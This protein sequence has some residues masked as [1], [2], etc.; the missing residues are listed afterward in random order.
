VLQQFVFEPTRYA[1]PVVGTVGSLEAITSEVLDPWGYNLFSG[2]L[3]GPLVKNKLSFFVSG[4]ALF[5][6]DSAPFAIDTPQLSDEQLASL[7]VSPQ[8]LQVENGDTG[9]LRYLPIPGGLPDTISFDDFDELLSVPEGFALTGR[10]PIDAGQVVTANDLTT[11]DAKNEPRNRYDIN[12]NFTYTPSSTISIRA[13]GAFTQDKFEDYNATSSLYN[14]LSLDGGSTTDRYRNND[15]QTLRLFTT[16]THRISDNTFYQLQ[17]DFIDYKTWAYPSGFSKN[18]DDALAVG[19]IDDPRNSTLAAYRTLADTDGDGTTDSYVRRYRDGQLF[20]PS[21]VVSLWTPLGSPP[22]GSATFTKSNNKQLRFSGSATTQVGVHQLEFGGEFEQQTN[23]FYSVAG[24]G[25]SRFL[26]DDPTAANCGAEN[27]DASDVFDSSGNLIGPTAYNNLPFR[28]FRDRANWYGYDFRGL[29]EVDDQNVDNYLDTSNE[30]NHNVE[31]WK[32]VYYAGYIQD[33]I[34]FRDLVINLGLRVDVFDSNTLVLKDPG[35]P[36][37]IIRVS[38]TALWQEL[39]PAADI[40]SN[41]GDDYAVYF[42]DNGQIVGFR[43]IDGD[44]FDA[45]GQDSNLSSIDN[46]GT[47]RQKPGSQQLSSEIFKDYEPEVTWMPR[48]GVSFPVTNQALFFASYNITSQ[49]PREQAFAPFTTYDQISGQARLNN[50]DLKPEKT[51]QYELGFRQ[52]LG[53]R[54]AFQVSA[55]LRQQKDLIQIRNI[56]AIGLGIGSYGNVQNIDFATTKGLELEFDLRRTNG[57]ALRANYTFSLAN[58]TGSDSQSLRIIQWRGTLANGLY[59]PNFIS[60]AGFDRRHS[61]NLSFDYRLG[62]G[63]GPKIGDTAFLQNFG[64]N[65]SAQLGSGMPYTALLS[66]SEVWSSFTDNVDGSINGR[67]LPWYSILDIRVDRKFDIGDRTDLTAF[68]WIENLLD[69]DNTLGVWRASG[70]PDTDGFLDTDN[71]AAFADNAGS[72]IGD[73]LARQSFVD[74]YRAYVNNPIGNG[75]SHYSG[76]VR[77]SVPRR[78]RLGFR[79]NF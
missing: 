39:D 48:I 67:R 58:A 51:V 33:K 8:V 47:Q 49:R 76:G 45:D 9:E 34:E 59:F 6:S 28:A 31:P 25:L 50:P 70:L 24:N 73:D 16:W 71:G 46:A 38:D 18:V 15:D 40:P 54:A 7:L 17:F 64:I 4:E 41:I 79:L 44:F 36:A 30:A 22:T 57:V 27:L 60:P 72:A 65:A 5:Q 62:A 37:P 26:C 10:G 74:H 68:V 3:G 69:Q 61:A 53:S 20:S 56:N 14:R 63:E 23:R 11:V 12:G 2:T 78:V 77:Y 1:H 13:G 29:N 43:N 75:G 19:D 42:N 55:F 35:A 21:A 66:P 32:P 52:S